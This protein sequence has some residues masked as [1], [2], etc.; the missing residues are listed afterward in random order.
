MK[1]IIC[2]AMLGFLTTGAA[3]AGNVGVEKDPAYINIVNSVIN[4][5]YDVFL[6]G[7]QSAAIG[8][9]VT[10]PMTASQLIA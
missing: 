4:D 3:L 7:G 1:K 6:S 2:T 8:D 10:D 5:D 9:N